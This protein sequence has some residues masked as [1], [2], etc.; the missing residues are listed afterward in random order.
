[1][2]SGLAAHIEVDRDAAHV[3]GQVEL[4]NTAALTLGHLW[5]QGVDFHF[6][7]DVGP[8]VGVQLPRA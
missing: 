1:M 7:H 2:V 5:Q 4:P 3:R 8:V 6:G